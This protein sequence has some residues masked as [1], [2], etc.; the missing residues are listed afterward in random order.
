[1]PRQPS[2]SIVRQPPTHVHRYVP[3]ARIITYDWTLNRAAPTFAE[4]TSEHSSMPMS[5]GAFDAE[6]HTSSRPKN[7]DHRA[8]S[9]RRTH[10]RLYP[11][12]GVSKPFLFALLQRRP[13]RT[14]FFRGAKSALP[15]PKSYRTM[16]VR[17]RVPG[18]SRAG[19]SSVFEKS[20]SDG[21]ASQPGPLTTHK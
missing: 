2:T 10:L 19:L 13:T 7:A 5:P 4:N 9:E 1:V 12:C 18:A 6:T 17:V 11:V 21:A 8:A 20:A 16:Q 3:Y 15:D 14:A